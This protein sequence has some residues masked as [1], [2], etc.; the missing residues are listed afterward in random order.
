MMKTKLFKPVLIAALVLLLAL[1]ALTAAGAATEYAYTNPE[2]G[3]R[4]VILD[5]LHLLSDSERVQLITDMQPLTDYGNIAF[6]TTEQSTS[7]EIDQARLKRKELF[8]YASG[9]VF[10]INMNVRKLTIQ[11]YGDMNKRVSDSLARSITDNVKSFATTKNYYTCAKTAFAQMHDVCENRT[12]SEP[13]KFSSF[14]VIAVMAGLILALGI[15]FSKRFNP[16]QQEMPAAS[17]RKYKAKGSF[18]PGVQLEYIGSTTVYRPPAPKVTVHSSCS[19][20][21]SG[22]SCSSCSSCSSGSSC[23]SC[24][25]GGCGSGGSS[26]F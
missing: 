10:A 25:G 22:S 9:G 18:A 24:G 16:M 1:S 26:S 3:Y 14:A 4:V 21:S 7:N 19:S 17:Y 12:I 2:T 23:S 5:E 15:A 11:T 13:M 20:C 6:W 8:E